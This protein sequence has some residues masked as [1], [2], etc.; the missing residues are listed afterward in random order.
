MRIIITDDYQDAVRSLDC[1]DRLSGHEVTIYHDSVKDTG[2]LAARL[3][4]ADA[5][6]LIRERTAISEPLLALLPELKLILQTG[7][8]MPHVDIEAC[9]RHGVA[10][11]AGGGTPFA[12]AELTW[13]LVL[14]AM[15]RIPQEVARMKAGQWQTTLGLGLHGR[16]LGI[17][18]YGKIGSLVAG[19]G[20]T[21]GMRVLVWGREGTLARARA[22]GFESVDSKSA[23]FGQSDVLSL[24][25]KLVEETRG[26]VT[27]ADLAEM[28]PSS[29]LVNTS[30]AG[31]IAR[32]ALEEAL[33][34]G[35]PGY[36]AVDVYESEPFSDHPLLHM[37]N[38]ICTP[39][40]GYVEKDSYELYFGTAFDQLLAFAAGRPIDII[41]PQ[42]LE[43]P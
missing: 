38:V 30:R 13:G 17:F 33:R 40:L 34:A 32:G 12:P 5:L 3:R 1:F 37:E 36:A 43:R 28:K 42:A 24:H 26:I 29:L 20:R 31:L 7:R 14:A 22:D 16:T 23:L 19:Y 8:A 21:F 9:T 15:R 27:A 6:V 39:H 4:D 41:N 18:G 2:T 10:V 35:R 25:L 11:A